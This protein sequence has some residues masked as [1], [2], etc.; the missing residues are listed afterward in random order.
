MPPFHQPKVIIITGPCGVGKTEITDLF[1]Q[2]F[3]INLIRGDDIKEELFPE[4][5]NI[6][7][8]PDK[9]Q[10]VKK[11]IF[12][13]AKDIYH[14]GQSA[15][16]DYVILG[17]AYIQT[18]QQ[19]FG[20]DLYFF[21]LLPDLETIYKRDEERECWTAGKAVI[22]HIHERYTTLKKLIGEETYIDSSHQSPEVTFQHISK[23]LSSR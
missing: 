14:K 22:D 23:Y 21:V 20:R 9:L 15:V 12:E 17:E 3:D 5:S 13:Q 10:Q 4:I 6:T 1:D 7:L 18:F 11:I 8:Y 19:A 2:Q 16:I